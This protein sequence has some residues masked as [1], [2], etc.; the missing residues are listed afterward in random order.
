MVPASRTESF[1]QTR[2]DDRLEGE[3]RWITIGSHPYNR[4]LM[5]VIVWTMRADDLGPV[6][7]IISARRAT[8]EERLAYEERTYPI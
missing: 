1:H 5:L 7:W 8:R 6:T 4:S 3:D 2:L